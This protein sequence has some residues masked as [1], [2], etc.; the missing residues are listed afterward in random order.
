MRPATHKTALASMVVAVIGFVSGL[1]SP[2]SQAAQ[3]AEAPP[4]Y[5]V[6]LAKEDITPDY[7][8]RLNG[9]GFRRT[10]SEG[11]TLPIWAKVLAISRPNEPAVVL[12][13]VDNLGVPDELVQQLAERL[14]KKAGLDAR[15]PRGH[16]DAY[17]YRADVDRRQPDAL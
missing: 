4:T 3:S 10:E 9:F 8:I 6:G 1:A 14:S 5:Q 13:A 12:I 16:G 17:A 7:P 11:V 15:A 2:Q